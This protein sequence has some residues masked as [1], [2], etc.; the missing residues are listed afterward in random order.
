[1]CSFARLIMAQ[2]GPIVD[3]GCDIF[4]GR[5]AGFQE[6]SVNGTIV[7]STRRFSWRPDAVSFDATG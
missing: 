4:S 3:P 5:C 1:M 7:I 6:S 2:T